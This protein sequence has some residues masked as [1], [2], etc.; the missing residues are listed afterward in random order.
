MCSIEFTIVNAYFKN[1]NFKKYPDITKFIDIVVQH[2]SAFTCKPEEVKATV[3]KILSLLKSKDDILIVANGLFHM[4]KKFN[5]LEIFHRYLEE[6]FDRIPEEM[7]N[8][9]TE[10]NNMIYLSE[11]VSPRLAEYVISRNLT[12][13]EAE[14]KNMVSNDSEI[15]ALKKTIE[16]LK[17]APKV[18]TDVTALKQKVEEQEK[19]I[20][21]FKNKLQI[22]KSLIN[23]SDKK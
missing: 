18:D 17:G 21:D 16:E 22:V 14:N 2:E 23:P 19:I 15:A 8:K 10:K 12:K 20:E 1:D 4:M 7:M 9:F 11:H 13:Y 3:T 6:A 5:N